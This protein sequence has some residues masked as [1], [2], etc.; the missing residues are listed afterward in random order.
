[1]TAVNR[2]CQRAILLEGGTIVDDGGPARVI[3]AYLAAGEGEKG[4][5]FWATPEIAP[6]NDR[7]RLRAVRVHCEGRLTSQVRID[8]DV[9]IE[10]EFWN[11]TAAARRLCPFLYLLDGN[12]ATVLS[13][14]PFPSAN[15]LPDTWFE[16]PHP[17]GVFR[18]RCTL[19]ANF[20]NEGRYYISVYMTRFD[21]V[22]IEAAAPEVVAIDV[23]DTGVMRT[24]A[25]DGPWHGVVRVRLPW[26]TEL[27]ERD[28]P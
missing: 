10:V 28:A 15:T 25:G 20:L 26:T 23:L 19:P 7:V 6:G 14:A 17:T 8:R 13:T 3:Q 27:L 4:Q 12:G 1:M 9:T 24:D 22:T 18:C 16:A 2:L 21:P 5:A 11:L